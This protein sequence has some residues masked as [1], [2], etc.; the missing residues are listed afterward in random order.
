MWEDTGD[1]Y[2]LVIRYRYELNGGTY[3]SENFNGIDMSSSGRKGKQRIADEFPEGMQTTCK[4]N[5]RDPTKA[6]LRSRPDGRYVVRTVYHWYFFL[7]D[8]EV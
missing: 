7:L 6:I 4:V 3:R 1:T 2:K 8:W 5:P